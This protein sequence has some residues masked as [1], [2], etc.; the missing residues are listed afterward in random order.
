MIKNY[1][2]IV[3][4]DGFEYLGWQRQNEGKTIQGV[5]EKTLTTLL[6]EKILIH[7][8][9]RTDK[10]VHAYA[11]VFS[12]KTTTSVPAENIKLVLNQRLPK[13]IHINYIEKVDDLFHARYLAKGKRYVYKIWKKE[14]N[15]FI[16]RYYY[17]FTKEI[18]IQRIIDA[19]EILMGKHDFISFMASKSNVNSTVR[20]IYSIDINNFDDYFEIEFYGNG[21]LYNMVRIIVQHL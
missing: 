3:A 18:D 21:F 9:G 5:L 7:G 14:S 12:F 17:C 13:S 6:K 20:E 11:Q 16:S 1:K 4:Y 15:P 19:K 2:C 10:G 8:S